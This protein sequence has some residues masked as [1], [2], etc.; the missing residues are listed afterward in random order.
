MSRGARQDMWLVF[1]WGGRC[2]WTLLGTCWAFTLLKLTSFG[3]WCCTQDFQGI[4]INMFKF[5]AEVTK[6]KVE[7]LLFLAEGLYKIH[8]HIIES[9]RQKTIDRHKVEDEAKDAQHDK[10]NGENQLQLFRQKEQIE[11]RDQQI[12]GLKKERDN[13]WAKYEDAKGRV[14]MTWVQSEKHKESILC[15]AQRQVNVANRK[16]DAVKGFCRPRTQTLHQQSRPQPSHGGDASQRISDLESQ[17]E[18]ARKPCKIH[19]S[20]ISKLEADN[21]DPRAQLE[22]KDETIGAG[23]SNDQASK[24]AKLE[25]DVVAFRA[26][27]EE[28]DRIIDTE[29]ASCKDHASKITR[30]EGD[31]TALRDELHAKTMLPEWL[32]SP[33]DVRQIPR[34]VGEAVYQYLLASGWQEI[35][36]D[37]TRMKEGGQKLEEMCEKQKELIEKLQSSSSTPH[38]D[39]KEVKDLQ[40]LLDDCKEELSVSESIREELNETISKLKKEGKQVEDRL[41]NSR[42]A[43]SRALQEKH[44]LKEELEELKK[45]AASTPPSDLAARLAYTATFPNGA[46]R[47]KVEGLNKE[48][49]CLV[50]SLQLQHNITDVTPS[51]LEQICKFSLNATQIAGVRKEEPNNFDYDSH[52]LAKILEFWSRQRFGKSAVLGVRTKE[53]KKDGFYYQILGNDEGEMVVWVE[54]LVP[55]SDTQIPGMTAFGFPSA[56]DVSGGVAAT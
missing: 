48:L 47:Q 45:P 54:R 17:F 37:N 32:T 31:N 50:R 10:V 2:L 34:E 26:Q 51:D 49:R 7:V 3:Q 40:S 30:L 18:D 15:E 11:T 35:L 5:D 36:R 22:A 25:N 33:I 28:K 14:R 19:T 53:I 24:I 27:V 16:Y 55:T 4:A 39:S 1:S 56:G 46:R 13:L 52:Q 41:E 6:I 8:H 9:E 23:S 12:S 21:K 29:T 38:T 43:I 44:K 42:A 20:R